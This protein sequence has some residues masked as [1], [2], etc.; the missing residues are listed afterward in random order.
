MAE[1][2]G[3]T[4]PKTLPCCHKMSNQTGVGCEGMKDTVELQQKDQNTEGA[5]I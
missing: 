5:E 3:M 1:S 2:A 4:L